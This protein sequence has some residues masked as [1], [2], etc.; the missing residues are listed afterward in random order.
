[1]DGGAD[2]QMVENDLYYAFSVSSDDLIAKEKI[3]VMSKP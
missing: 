2:V 1:M 3:P